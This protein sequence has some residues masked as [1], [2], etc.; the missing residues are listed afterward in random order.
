[1]GF[2]R[3]WRSRA[4][5]AAASGTPSGIF[6]LAGDEAYRGGYLITEE[7]DSPVM[8]L[9]APLP[10]NDRE[11]TGAWR[12]LPVSVPPE[13]LQAGGFYLIGGPGQQSCEVVR[14][15]A[16]L[17]PGQPRR[18]RRH[19]FR[20]FGPVSHPAGTW[21]RRVTVERVF[22]WARWEAARRAEP[23]GPGALDTAGT[24]TGRRGTRI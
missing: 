18:I 24:Q 4:Q 9:T 22:D 12:H 10:K 23:S 19:L 2:R 17:V 8:V 15:E 7:P 6:S 21:V 11:G 3:L 14:V 13:M 16:G 1:L 5:S 20:T